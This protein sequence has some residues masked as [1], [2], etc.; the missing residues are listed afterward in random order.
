M[1][2]GNATRLTSAES[3]MS[4][5]KTSTQKSAMKRVSAGIA[6]SSPTVAMIL[7]DSVAR[8]SGRNTAAFSTRPRSGANTRITTTAVG[9]ASHPSPVFS[10]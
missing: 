9:R 5:W 3:G 8:A 6:S 10:S 7:A 4:K 2:L 1:P